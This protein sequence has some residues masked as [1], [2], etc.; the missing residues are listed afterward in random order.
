MRV[1]Q[2]IIDRFRALDH[3]SFSP[4]ACTVILGPNNA[5]KSTVLEA[6]DLLL[7]HGV[8]RPRPAPTEVDYFGRD[9]TPGFGIEAVIGDLHEDFLAEVREHLEGWREAEGELVPEPD[10]EGI[11]PVVRVRAR[12]SS[13]LDLV[14]EFAKP[15]SEGA[16]FH[17]GLRTEVGWVF[18]GRAR[19]PAHQLAFYQGGLLDRLFGE[20][21]LDPAV[22][23][24]RRSLGEGAISVNEDGAVAGVLALL[25]GDLRR[26][27]LLE[28]GESPLFEVGGVSRRELLQALRLA[29]PSADV[30][31]PLGRQGRGAQRLLLV[32][33]LLRLAEAAGRVPIAG[34]EEPE[35]ALEPL[36]QAQLSRMLRSVADRG[37]QVFVVTH[38]AEIARAF[39][40][41]DFLLLNERSAGAGARFLRGALSPAVLQAYERRL[42]GAV[43]RGLF[44]RIP[45]LVEGPGD[46]AIFETFWTALADAGNLRP[47]HEIGLDVVNA[48]GAGS[49]PMLA[50]VLD[51]A[52]KSV[53]VWAEQDTQEVRDVVTRL[54]QEDHCSAFLLHDPSPERSNLEGALA[55]GC[56]MAGLA[57]AMQAL[58]NDRGYDWEEQRAD[59]VSRC[60]GID[61]ARRD[62][63]KTATSIEELFDA[64][65]E[66][67][68]RAVIASALGSKGV[69]PF[70]MK[71]A[72]QARIVAAAIVAAE[73]VPGSFASALAHLNE[74]VTAGCQKSVDIPLSDG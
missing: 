42:D 60:D 29:L 3:L 41:E 57:Q 4:G 50:A 40:I 56:G 9:P 34:L 52:G 11:E 18:D 2:L 5:G 74:W 10:G 72:R 53:V 32:S 25:A 48:E 51:E 73:G 66:E 14:H 27:G 22:D 64:L 70:E 33:V 35:E 44:A 43:V 59:L 20:V 16:R 46:R 63:A 36:R 55:Y 24:L 21:S 61:D 19:D 15:E 67:Q 23:E 8:G 37:G 7:H 58:A 1:R 38:S 62:A 6:L 28:T 68:A 54:R 30:T 26:L 31:I 13:D 71:G 65:G 47:A 69:K 45:V 39:E 17:P 49:F 12:A